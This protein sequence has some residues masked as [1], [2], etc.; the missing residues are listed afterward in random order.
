MTEPIIFTELFK[1]LS[2]FSN[3]ATNNDEKTLKMY[4][5]FLDTLKMDIMILHSEKES[6][7]IGRIIGANGF[8]KYFVKLNNDINELSNWKNDFGKY[9]T[10]GYGQFYTLLG[11]ILYDQ[12]HTKYHDEIREEIKKFEE[13]MQYQVDEG[14][15]LDEQ[16]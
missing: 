8:G 14:I 15:L 13:W 3:M 7:K 6:Y 5:E 10:W 16:E 2:T 4:G 12:H 11:I 9:N 1:A